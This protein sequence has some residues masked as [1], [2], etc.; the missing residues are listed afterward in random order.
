MR[1]LIT[2]GAGF[3]GS[4]LALRLVAEG[5]V[6]SVLDTLSPQIHGADPVRTSPLYAS[7]RE[8]VQFHHGSVCDETDLKRSLV[9][10]DAVVHLAAETGTGQSMYEISRYA[11]TNVG[12]TARILDFL[13]N[14]PHEVRRVVV[15]SSRAIYG[16]GKYQTE[17][18]RIVY[19]GA[20]LSNDMQAG[21]EFRSNR[22]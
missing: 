18:G 1:I 16:E 9:H 10:Q 6:V 12:G 22:S 20:R 21:P 4:H 5:H 15:A 19:P 7:I 17:D 8:V 3:I 2:G 11:D 13:A 14:R